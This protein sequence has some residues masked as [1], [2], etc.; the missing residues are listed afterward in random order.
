MLWLRLYRW[1]TALLWQVLWLLLLR[2]K[3]LH[4]LQLLQPVYPFERDKRMEKKNNNIQLIKMFLI[5]E[6]NF[7]FVCL[8]LFRKTIIRTFIATQIV[9]IKHAIN[10][11]IKCNMDKFQRE[12]TENWNWKG[13]KENPIEVEIW[14][15][16]I[17]ENLSKP[18]SFHGNLSLCEKRSETLFSI[19]FLLFFFFCVFF[20]L[21]VNHV[22]RA[23]NSEQ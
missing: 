3:L 6:F 9:R 14:E 4:L 10:S 5:K 18:H 17:H 12:N 20:L 22:K 21:N 15:T 23:E 16:P 11:I 7:F 2:F 1:F 8:S 19:L 13:K